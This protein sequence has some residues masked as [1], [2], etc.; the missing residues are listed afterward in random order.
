MVVVLYNSAPLVADLVASLPDGLAGVEYEL[1]GVDNDSSDGG[2]ELLEALAPDATVVR[3]G[4][5]GGYAAGINAGVAAAGEHSAVLVLNSDVRL[6]PGCVPE[7]LSRLRSKGV[8]IAVPRLLDAQG[9]VIESIRREPKA[10]RVLCD[11]LLSARL[12][13]RLL[14]LGE[15][16][17]DRRAYERE[18]Q[19][20]WA[21]GSTQLI[22]AECWAKCGPWDESFFLYCEETDFDLRARDAGFATVF[23]PSARAVHLEGGS[24]TSVDAL[25]VLQVR[26][27]VKLHRRR[28][29]AAA[30]A[31]FWLLTLLREASRAS[32]GRTK[33]RA[34]VRGLLDWHLVRGHEGSSQ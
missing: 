1:V 10:I 4:R 9:Q 17:T 33:N 3:T 27:R 11:A 31:V 34:A 19:V 22:S 14:S 5:N 2:A 16:V 30:T 24:S 25:W 13:G 21:E 8:G 29:G 32:L 28:H 12:A 15:V 6:E 18:H 20:D 7:M 23:V 26:N